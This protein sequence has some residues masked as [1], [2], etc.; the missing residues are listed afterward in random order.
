VGSWSWAGDYISISNLEGDAEAHVIY[1]R[2]V[3]RGIDGSL[4]WEGDR[5]HGGHLGG[6]A[7]ENPIPIGDGL[8]SF[9]A[10]INL[11]GDKQILAGRTLYDRLGNV[12]WHRDDLGSPFCDKNSDCV[13][14]SGLVAVG[15][16]DEDDYAEIVMVIDGTLRVLNHD[17]TE[18]WGPINLP[19]GEAGDVAIA[20]LTRDG[21]PEIVV[22]QNNVLQVYRYNGDL[23][24]TAPI[25]DPS[26]WVSVSIAD[27]N[28]NGWLEILHMDEVNF[29]LLDGATGVEYYRI[30]NTSM[31]VAE[32]PVI[33]DVTGDGQANFVVPGN[34]RSNLPAGTPGIRVFEANNGRW[35]SAR[36]LW[37]QHHYSINHIEDDASVPINEMPSWLTHNT[38]RAAFQGEHPAALPDITL[39]RVRPD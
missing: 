35:A 28:G 24:W 27:I 12:I 8:A 39:G 11:D 30:R 10:D 3:F 32:Y 25:E 26:G 9:A 13:Y 14:S 31:T 20:D 1:G 38:F 34:N 22:S 4:L 15:N 23:L 33:A 21:R 7:G 37:N 5:D 6:F 17:G 19:D 2:R 18:L 29:R 16:F 36:G